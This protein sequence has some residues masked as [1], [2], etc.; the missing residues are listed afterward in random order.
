MVTLN[1]P[2]EKNGKLERLYCTLRRR[3]HC[4]RE[5]DGDASLLAGEKESTGSIL[6]VELIILP[7]CTLL[8]ANSPSSFSNTVSTVTK[9][10][11]EDYGNEKAGLIIIKGG[12]GSGASS[13]PPSL[14]LTTSPKNGGDAAPGIEA[15]PRLRRHPTSRCISP[16]NLAWLTMNMA[17]I[18][19]ID[20]YFVVLLF[21]PFALNCDALA[22]SSSASTPP[23]RRAALSQLVA[24]IPL[25][26]ATPPAW[27]SLTEPQRSAITTVVLGSSQDRIGIELY[28]VPIGTRTFPAVKSVRTSG[29]AFAN[30]VVPGMVLLGIQGGSSRAVVERIKN[31]P[32][33]IVLQFYDLTKEEGRNNNE[34]PEQALKLAQ[35]QGRKETDS[36]PPVSS[37]GTGLVVKTLKK[38]DCNVK[39]K[40]GDTLVVN[41][42]G[43]VASPGGPVFAEASGAEFVL[44]KKQ[45]PPGV[46]IGLAGMCPGEVR[47]LDIPSALGFGPQGSPFDQFD[48]PGDVRLWWKAE[49]VKLIKK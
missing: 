10:M 47:T 27:A 25:F 23:T 16:E 22:P 28:D 1:Q 29:E 15:R 4:R 39:A 38:G 2:S 46:D 37:K 36:G 18:S 24:S 30:G 49:L 34:S 7:F 20:V 40:R 8:V 17:F 26:V 14:R 33:P 42:E 45:V 12:N 3:R 19:F 21:N 13:L 44:G 35:D 32:Y 41:Y 43:R 9:S 6:A 48:V 31:G 11:M 5:V